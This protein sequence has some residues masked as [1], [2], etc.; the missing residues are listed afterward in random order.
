MASYL[1]QLTRPSSSGDQRN[2]SQ[3]R[4]QTQPHNMVMGAQASL[5]QAQQGDILQAE[6]SHVSMSS[7]L[8]WQVTTASG[9]R[10]KEEKLR[11]TTSLADR[12]KI[13][14]EELRKSNEV[15][16]TELARNIEENGSLSTSLFSTKEEVEVL[17]KQVK[18]V[19][20]QIRRIRSEREELEKVKVERDAELLRLAE[21]FKKLY[22]AQE[23][24]EKGWKEELTK[25]GEDASARRAR[26]EC[27]KGDGFDELRL[28]EEKLSNLG[29]EIIKTEAFIKDEEKDGKTLDLKIDTV[30]K[31]TKLVKVQTKKLIEEGGQKEEELKKE[32]SKLERDEQ[33]LMT[34]GE[35]VEASIAEKRN[36]VDGRKA[37]CLEMKTDLRDL[38]IAIMALNAKVEDYEA[39]KIT[40]EAQLVES[41]ELIKSFEKKLAVM[42]EMKGEIEVLGGD[43]KK[44]DDK[45]LV[46]EEEY[47]LLG[48]VQNEKKRL[49]EE[50]QNL[51]Q[52]VHNYESKVQNCK[53]EVSAAQEELKLKSKNL[54]ALE[55]KVLEMESMGRNKVKQVEKVRKLAETRGKT[56]TGSK[57]SSSVLKIKL[58][59]L[60]AELK[61]TNDASE[62]RKEKLHTMKIDLKNKNSTLGSA[63]EIL[64]AVIGSNKNFDHD[65]VEAEKAVAALT[66]KALKFE[67]ESSKVEAGNEEVSTN[68]KDA[69]EKNK[70]LNSEYK[71]LVEEVGNVEEEKKSYEL[72]CKEF[73]SINVVA[74][75]ENEKL[76][77]SVVKVEGELKISKD[78]M[79]G[80]ENI[81][82][83]IKEKNIEIKNLEKD[84]KNAKKNHITVFKRKDKLAKQLEKN[85][86]V[87]EALG[88]D[89]GIN[90]EKIKKAEE[91]MGQLKVELQRNQEDKLAKAEAVEAVKAALAEAVTESVNIGAEVKTIQAGLEAMK[92]ERSKLLFEVK[93]G[94]LEFQGLLVC[95]DR[96]FSEFRTKLTEE[97]A[98]FGKK[99]NIMKKDLEERQTSAKIS[100]DDEVSSQ[101]K[102]LATLTKQTEVTKAEE[103]QLQVKLTERKAE[104]DNL[105]EKLKSLKSR[106]GLT[107]S[108]KKSRTPLGS[109]KPYSNNSSSQQSRSNTSSSQ[110]P[111]SM[112]LTATPL[113]TR[114]TPGTVRQ[115]RTLLPSGQRPGMTVPQSPVRSFLAPPARNTPSS[116]HTRPRKKHNTKPTSTPKTTIV[117]FD[118]VMG[119]S[120]DMD[121]S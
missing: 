113:Q 86:G 112:S 70:V 45:R 20:T 46:A 101:Q 56:V 98:D 51:S 49:E 47:K 79:E 54:G 29:D 43:L 3:S 6:R 21:S 121:S 36:H 38:G 62:V 25:R 2:Q 118:S 27:D 107:T 64:D 63:T 9:L 114:A 100:S 4:Q 30:I 73:K 109:I 1:P 87:S 26:R 97:V 83:L 103:S 105:S 117:D 65:R 111:T 115:S 88:V 78:K 44:S 23:D 11:M 57:T 80:S 33:G 15:L 95:K 8:E 116:Q 106:Q 53:S 19:S 42:E 66:E 74:K 81:K 41:K 17:A 35:L 14:I 120:D 34:K 102:A 32:I 84:V 104:V 10:D 93:K 60:A 82:N 68:I 12:Q 22:V 77:K 31:E 58:N 96:E 72:K 90:V 37:S 59:S 67:I 48:E 18:T 71:L 76:K 16:G 61:N 40:N 13:K 52:D 55:T 91:V 89:I 69:E 75:K 28:L 85:S 108:S 50:N 7:L 119:I 39:R 92:V 94:A 5:S 99:L 110:P 24:K